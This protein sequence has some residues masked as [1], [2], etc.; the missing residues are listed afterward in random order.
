M[1]QDWA[2][3]HCTETNPHRVSVTSQLWSEHV[4][5]ACRTDTL[6]KDFG[7]AGAKLFPATYRFQGY[8]AAVR[9]R[10]TIVALSP[11]H[12]VFN[13]HLHHKYPSV[14]MSSKHR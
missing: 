13:N 9:E 8:C 2:S 1:K 6:T 4:C 3:I 14:Q 10:G 5:F 12:S 11:F 7:T